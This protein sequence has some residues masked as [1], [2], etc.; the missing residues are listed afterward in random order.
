MHE[1]RSL[2]AF[3][4]QV[5]ADGAK[6]AFDD[7]LGADERT[8]DRFQ[9]AVALPLPA[10]FVEFHRA[11]GERSP[12]HLFRDARQRLGWLL[13][14]HQA[15]KLALRHERWVR[16]AKG[17]IEPDGWLVY[18]AGADA[19]PYVACAYADVAIEQSGSGRIYAPS[20]AHL[21]FA[22]GWELAHWRHPNA[23]VSCTDAVETVASALG[24]WSR[25]HGLKPTW[26]SGGARWF[27]DPVSDG[28]VHAPVR[29]RLERH[30][31]HTRVY[32]LSPDDAFADRAAT[33]LV[34]VLR[35]A[36]RI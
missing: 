5:A 36:S 2:H 10:L 23:Q 25:T 22:A 21:V 9:E 8:L 31:D 18:P 32:V 3:L 26:F 6:N 20:F 7:V 35:A 16:I 11:F 34:S 33:A 1:H 15:G 17:A 19:E 30:L 4:D 28:E 29:L 12:L 14:R 24:E 27:F 13:E